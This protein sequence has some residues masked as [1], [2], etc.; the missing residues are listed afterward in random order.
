MPSKQRNGGRRRRDREKSMRALLVP[1]FLVLSEVASE[2]EQAAQRAR[3][4]ARRLRD[5]ARSTVALLGGP[6]VAQRPTSA[7]ARRRTP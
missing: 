2:V 4:L 1:P 3:V 7:R 6:F 5:A